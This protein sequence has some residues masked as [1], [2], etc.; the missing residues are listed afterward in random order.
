MTIDEATLVF[1]RYYLLAIVNDRL[2]SSSTA[3]TIMTVIVGHTLTK[4]Y[5]LHFTDHYYEGNSM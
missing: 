4:M 3:K 2:K 5:V 1:N